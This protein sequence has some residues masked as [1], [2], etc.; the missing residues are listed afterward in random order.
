[1]RN[2]KL[3]IIVGIDG[4][5]KSTVVRRLCGLGYQT[6]HWRRL[7]DVSDEWADRVDNAVATM[8]ELRGRERTAFILDLVEGEWNACILPHLIANRDVVCDGFYLRS[9]AKELVFGDGDV[10]AVLRS[11][12][13]AGD[14]LVVL[15][16]VPVDVAE[17][18]KRG[19]EI[20]AYECF[21]SPTDFLEFQARQ[22]EQLLTI[23]NAWN[24]V[25][26][27]GTGRE[28]LVTSAVAGIL[29]THG[30]LPGAR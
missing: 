25:V 27:D 5:G 4:A 23:A 14:E 12:P 13:L 11:S 21:A 8:S 6:S 2:S 3:A 16:D 7:R 15:I 1:M 17:R 20:S 28:E 29:Q 19:E 22:R 26:V 18:R 24:H 30:V 10:D 9:L